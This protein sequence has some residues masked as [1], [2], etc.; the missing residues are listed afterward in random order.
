VAREGGAAGAQAAAQAAARAGSRPRVLFL[1]ADLPWPRDG[2][3]RI[4]TLHIL[5]SMCR[6]CDV[7]LVAMADPVGQ[8]D[9][10]Y[11]RSICRSVE[12]VNIPFTFGRHRLRQL[13]VLLR[14]LASPDPYRLRKFRSRRFE[15]A[16]RRHL[17]ETTYD[18]VHCDQFGALSYIALAPHGAVATAVHHNVESDI[19]RLA[20]RQAANPLR[21][22]FA[23][24]ERWKLERAERRLLARFDHVFVLAP[25][26]AELLRALGID[27]TTVIPMPA[28][29]VA[30]RDGVPPPGHRVLTLGSMSWYGVADG[31]MWFHDEV[32]P[33]VRAAVPDVEWELI[34]PNA[35][36]SIRR[37][38]EEPGILVTGYVDELAPHFDRARVGVVPLRIAGGVRLKLLDFMARGLPAVATS[39]GARGL[40]I[41]DGAGCFQ[42]DDPAT[43][44][45]AVVELLTDDALWA[46]AAAAGREFVREHHSTASLDRAIAE[47]IDL[48][49]QR[50]RR[51]LGGQA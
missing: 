29:D 9:L 39:V 7:D 19:Y 6:R 38:S 30:P 20:A 34:G 49:T 33:G 37:L 32:L 26:D 27:R 31:L 28:P 51:E 14:S 22:V 3:G 35:P 5:E 15:V 13:A 50:H 10:A 18:V 1:A 40:D 48:A 8:P 4:A 11:L 24:N 47:G 21:K 43:F 41:P 17:S 36:A 46:E 16:V 12:V 2:G 45:T 42:R 25:D 23:A 44:A